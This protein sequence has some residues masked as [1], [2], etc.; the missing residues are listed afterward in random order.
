MM[1]SLYSVE[2]SPA[3]RHC[4]LSKAFLMTGQW[5]ELEPSLKRTQYVGNTHEQELY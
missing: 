3:G 1:G 4:D 5:K 2:L